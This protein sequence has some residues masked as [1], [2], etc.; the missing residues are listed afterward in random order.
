MWALRPSRG[1][2]TGWGGGAEW[3]VQNS[4]GVFCP[5]LYLWTLLLSISNSVD[6][7][8]DGFFLSCF[9]SYP[10]FLQ[11]CFWTSKLLKHFMW[12]CSSSTVSPKHSPSWI[13]CRNGI[14]GKKKKPTDLKDWNSWK[15]MGM[16]LEGSTAHLAKQASRTN[17]GMS[18]ISRP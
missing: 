4:A 18:V 5:S 11:F 17:C 2:S 9:N 12:F 14:K 6:L 7:G 8:S 16:C 15:F 13:A 3:L 10:P 1:W